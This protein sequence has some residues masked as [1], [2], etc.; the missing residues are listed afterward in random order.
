VLADTSFLIDLMQDDG[1]AK[2]KAEKLIGE[3]TPI[4][5]G[6]PTIFELYVGVGLAV[7]S[8][9]ERE[10]VLDALQSLT[11]LPLDAPSAARAGLVYAQ[12]KKEGATIDP[13]DAMIAGIALESQQTLLTRNT[14]HFLGIPGLKV[15]GY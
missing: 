13:E 12:K 7:K 14:K 3:S 8:S 15:E 2:A 11:Q 4:I 5:V 9:E 10:K 1:R 6:T